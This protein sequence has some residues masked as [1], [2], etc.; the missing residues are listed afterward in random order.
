[1][2]AR[3]WFVVFNLGARNRATV[4]IM[5][6]IVLTALL[7]LRGCSSATDA[8][9]RDDAEAGPTSASPRGVLLEPSVSQLKTLEQ[10]W[11][12]AESNDFYNAPQ[13]SQFIPYDWFL[14]LEQPD[15]E[16]L[17]LAPEHIHALGYL[18]RAKDSAGNPDGLPI[19]F[20]KDAPWDGKPTLGLTCAACHTTQIKYRGTAFLVDGAPAL[21]DAA[22]MQ[23][24]LAESLRATLADEVKFERFAASVL[25]NPTDDEKDALRQ[26]MQEFADLRDGYNARNFPSAN[27]V[28]FGPGRVDA[29]GAIL[30]EVTSRFLQLDENVKP[31]DA[32]V[33]YPFLWDAPQHD[34][35]Q[36]NGAAENNTNQLAR[37]VLG[38]HRIGALGRNTG[39]VL[40]VFGTVHPESPTAVLGG[41][42]SSVDRDSL[43]DIEESLHKLWSPQWPAEFGAIDPDKAEAGR[44][45]YQAHCVQ[46]H[47]DS[48]VRDSP[49]RSVKAVMA[50]VDTDDTMWWNFAARQ[51]RT[52]MLNGRRRG[53]FNPFDTLGSEE[54][55]SELLKHMVLRAVIGPEVDAAD[56]SAPQR[57][58][59]AIEMPVQMGLQIESGVI[60]GEFSNVRLEPAAEGRSN[61]TVSLTRSDVQFTSTDT[62]T[63]QSFSLRPTEQGEEL[64]TADG[65]IRALASL[66]GV[67]IITPPL[68]QNAS[69]AERRDLLDLRVENARIL[70][71]YKARPLNGI[72]AT[73]PYLHNGSVPNL[74]ELLKPAS[75]DDP[76]DQRV[77]KFFVGNREFDPTHVGYQSNEGPFEF[78]ATLAGNSNAGHEFGTHLN[79]DQRL[80]LI[81]YLK[82]L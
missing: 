73:A 38:T 40:G 27:G 55:A 81:E 19:G 11:S 51:S 78:D 28:A 12:D 53:L 20:V 1:M 23:H 67:T 49:N 3:L 6:S 47:D 8:T 5:G 13:G 57:E 60:Q 56:L 82:S 44:A 18:P 24:R 52:G 33:S 22:T 2:R 43:I 80:E 31:A 41:Y 16:E 21:G 61:V 14:H 34:V 10:N 37:P 66:P 7:I 63:P 79:H 58:A 62:P 17:F 71:K 64:Q 69:A 30:N 42:P 74:S 77:Q 72:W 9:V 29:F 26:Q 54:P 68:P 70:P 48:I 76:N 36:W 45:L 46:C 50:F 15:S 4:A 35:V 59:L 25:S 32:P 65:T 39:E 75:A